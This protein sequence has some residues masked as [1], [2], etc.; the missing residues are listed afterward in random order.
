MHA[1]MHANCPVLRLGCFARRGACTSMRWAHTACLPCGGRFLEGCASRQAVPACQQCPIGMHAWTAPRQNSDYFTTPCSL[2]PDACMHHNLEIGYAREWLAA[3][4]PYGGGPKSWISMQGEHTYSLLSYYL[5][6]PALAKGRLYT[7]VMLQA[8]Q[9]T[10]SHVPGA[11]FQCPTF[12]TASIC[13]PPL[14]VPR[15]S[16]LWRPSRRRRL[17]ASC[18]VCG[19]V[20]RPQTPAG[21]GRRLCGGSATVRPHSWL[22][23]IYS[24]PRAGPRSTVAVDPSA[25]VLPS[26]CHEHPHMM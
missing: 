13:K 9:G 23:A 10:Q 7:L 25:P 4:L 6:S 22:S 5:L 21:V 18:S 12:S 19:G 1:C 8:L 2:P 24:G 14:Q 20:T 16:C 17:C 3:H 11:R 15:Y 26:S